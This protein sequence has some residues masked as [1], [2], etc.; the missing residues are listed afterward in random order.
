[1]YYHYKLPNNNLDY[2]LQALASDVNVRSMIREVIWD[3]GSEEDNIDGEEDD[4]DEEDSD[5]ID[6]ED[7]MMNEVEVDMKEYLENIN[8][9]VEWVGPSNENVPKNEV[10]NFEHGINLDDFESASDSEN[11]GKRKKALRK[12][13]REHEENRSVDTNSCESFYAG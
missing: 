12:L 10:E 9:E 13:R 3:M 11:D 7:P 5:Y 2:A 4:S 1:M 6:D 8:K